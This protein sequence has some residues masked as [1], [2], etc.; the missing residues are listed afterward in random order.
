[1]SAK[2]A[3]NAI[4]LLFVSETHPL[5]QDTIIIPRPLLT[6]VHHNHTEG[7]TTISYIQL[8]KI[9]FSPRQMLITKINNQQV[10]HLIRLEVIIFLQV[11]GAVGVQ[12][13]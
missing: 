11:D 3:T 12:L 4:T 13:S 9:F 10:E 8:K 7:I 5:E 2:H 6:S 1:M